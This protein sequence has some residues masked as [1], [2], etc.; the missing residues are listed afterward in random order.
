MQSVMGLLI[1]YR[2]ID[3]CKKIHSVESESFLL[4]SVACTIS[5]SIVLKLKMFYLDHLFLKRKRRLKFFFI[6]FFETSSFV[7]KKK[8]K[9]INRSENFKS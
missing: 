5:N 8:K 3:N 7:E 9:Q 1:N 4:I 2:L 6:I